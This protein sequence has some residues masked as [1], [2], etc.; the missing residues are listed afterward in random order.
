MSLEKGSALGERAAAI[1]M[2]VLLLCLWGSELA[3]AVSSGCVFRSMS[4]APPKETFAEAV[5]AGRIRQLIRDQPGLQVEVGAAHAPLCRECVQM[6]RYV[7]QRDLHTDLLRKKLGRNPSPQELEGALSRLLAHERSDSPW[8]VARSG[9]GIVGDASRMPISSGKASLI[10]SKNYP[11]F[12]DASKHEPTIRKVLGEFSRV[13]R[14][15]GRVLLLI[16][17]PAQDWGLHARV[18]HSLG[19]L[20]QEIRGQDFSGILLRK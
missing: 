6:D 16:D 7:S 8:E 18:A 5:S 10:I 15:D 1:G 3:L 9:R 19:F 14:N 12:G 13:L 20:W 11:W 4:Q 2:S 17:E